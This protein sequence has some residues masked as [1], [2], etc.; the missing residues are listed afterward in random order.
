LN[1]QQYWRER[2]YEERDFPASFDLNNPDMHFADMAKGMG[3]AG[4]R[5]EKPE[6]IGPAIKQALE[7]DGPFLI[8]LVISNDVPNHEVHVPHSGH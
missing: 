2:S 1:I 8:D 3:V 4:V 7:H 6:E 5:V